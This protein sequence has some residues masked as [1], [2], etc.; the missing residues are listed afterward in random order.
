MNFNVQYA[1]SSGVLV[2]EI[3]RF[4]GQVPIKAGPV[5]IE[6]TADGKWSMQVQP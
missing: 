1:D 2:D 3:G 5:L 6:V 4:S